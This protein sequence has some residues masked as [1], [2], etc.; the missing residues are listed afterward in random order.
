MGLLPDSEGGIASAQ[1]TRAGGLRPPLLTN[2]GSTGQT[3]GAVPDLALGARP[4]GG[5][6]ADF[7]APVFN[8]YF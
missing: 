1:G 7:V 8:Q 6:F 3:L 4:C 2:W 5:D